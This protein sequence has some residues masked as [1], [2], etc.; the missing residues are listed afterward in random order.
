MLKPKGYSSAETLL[1]V[2]RQGERLRNSSPKNAHTVHIQ[3]CHIAHA[4]KKLMIGRCQCFGCESTK[5]KHFQISIWNY[6]SFFFFLFLI[7]LSSLLR[8]NSDKNTLFD[9]KW[10]RGE[11]G[12]FFFS[13]CQRFAYNLSE[14]SVNQNHPPNPSLLTQFSQQPKGSRFCAKTL[15]TPCL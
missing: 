4:E 11:K 2:E 10:L 14:Y 7:C 12:F 13:V 8:K 1:G 5:G 6:Y 3:F 15:I 9:P